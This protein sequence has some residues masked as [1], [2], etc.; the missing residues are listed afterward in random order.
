MTREFLE[1]LVIQDKKLNDKFQ[2]IY[3]PGSCTFVGDEEYEAI[4]KRY[5][6]LLVG[7]FG[8]LCVEVNCLIRNLI[9][10][11][12]EHCLTIEHLIKALQALEF[13]VI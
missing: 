7:E 6:D 4:E 9:S 3:I 11:V 10:Y 12:R 5:R 2:E 8:S 13:E 1:L